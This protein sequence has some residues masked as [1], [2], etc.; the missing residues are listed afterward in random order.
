[1]TQLDHYLLALEAM[2]QALNCPRY[3]IRTCIN[4][5]WHRKYWRY[6]GKQKYVC[7]VCHRL[8]YLAA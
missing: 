8:D 5:N 1:M 4:P 2:R 3:D 6:A 7:D